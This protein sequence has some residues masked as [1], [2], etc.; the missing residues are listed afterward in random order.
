MPWTNV[1]ELSSPCPMASGIERAATDNNSSSDSFRFRSDSLATVT[2]WRV[3]RA[4]AILDADGEK[5]GVF[6]KWTIGR[7]RGAK[8]VREAHCGTTARKMPC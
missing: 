4:D 1:R 7:W 2:P 6:A 5:L 3:R 8:G